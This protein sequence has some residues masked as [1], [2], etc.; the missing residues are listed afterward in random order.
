MLGISETSKVASG[1]VQGLRAS[2]AGRPSEVAF[3]FSAVKIWF[4]SER[5]HGNF[6]D[7]SD[8]W[9]EFESVAVNFRQS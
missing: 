6:A 1:K 7:K 3:L 9:L 5:S 8:L 4:E 2:G